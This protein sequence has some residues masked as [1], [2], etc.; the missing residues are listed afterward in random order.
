MF[1]FDNRSYLNASN[2]VVLNG[3]DRIL[4]FESGVDKIQ[5]SAF[6][7]STGLAPDEPVIPFG[8]CTGVD[9]DGAGPGTV[10]DNK[11]DGT[12]PTFLY[13]SRP[14]ICTGAATAAPQAG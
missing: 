10:I 11:P 7:Y 9:A 14:V 1:R 5:V 3:P 6:G 4:D 8:T 12:D 2:A 13:N